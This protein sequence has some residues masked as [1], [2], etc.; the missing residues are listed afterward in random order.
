MKKLNTI[1]YLLLLLMAISC[2]KDIVDQTEGLAALKPA[3]T[4]INAGDWKPILL[5]SSSEISVSTPLSTSNPLY[6]AE[7]NEIKDLQQN[8]TEDE[9]KDINYWAAGG[10]LRWNEIMRDLVAK[11]NLPP[12]QNDDRTYPIPSSANPFAYPLFPFSNPPYAARAYAYIAA[13]QYDA[14]VAAW[15]YKKVYARLAPYKNASD[16]KAMVPVSNLPSYPSEA[17]VIAGVTGEMMKLLF[18]TEIANIEQKVTHHELSMMRAGAATR[19]DIEAGEVLGRAVAKKFILKARSDKAGAAV[20]IPTQWAK[21]EADCMAD[22]RTPWISLETPKRPPMLPFFGDVVP[23]VMPRATLI[24]FL[25]PPPPPVGSAQLNTE[26]AEVFAFS[27]KQDRENIRIAHFWADGIGTSTPPGHWNAIAADDF[28]KQ[29]LS[30]VKWSRNIALLNLTLMDA[31][32]IT[33]LTKFKYY[34]PRPSQINPA[35]KTFNGIPN[36]PSYISG[37][38]TFSGSAATIL[39]YL[40]PSRAK[41]YKDMAIEASNSRLISGIHFRS[42]CEAGLAVGEKVGAYFI[43]KGKLDGA[44]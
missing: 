13:A 42:D 8:M 41:A 29:N 24:T 7:L 26:T 30:E 36:F 44:Q 32:I 22:G 15:H 12:Y 4:D 10:I 2:K 5:S 38:A 27:K 31:G 34:S 33:W 17:A 9:Q 19:S 40:T 3:S 37:H 43:E 18:P 39:G 16:I 21:L 35:I 25:P 14:L 23:I 11:Y 6:I 20:G 1:T 28:I